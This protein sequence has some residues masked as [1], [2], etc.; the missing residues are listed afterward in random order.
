[1]KFIPALI[2]LLAWHPLQA[3]LHPTDL[4]GNWRTLSIRVALNGE[5][6]WTLEASESDFPETLGI[7]ANYGEYR[8]DS[9]YTETY[10]AAKDSVMASSE[11]RWWVAQDSFYQQTS[12][13]KVFSYAVELK[14]DTATFR[15]WL[16]WDG[17]GQADD[18]YEGQ[19]LR[20]T[21]AMQTYYMV[22]LYRGEQAGDYSLEELEEIQQGHMANI[23][24][25]AKA[26]KLLLAGPFLDDGEL[27]GIFILKVAS[28]EEA[29]AFTQSD[30]AV[31]AGRLRMEVKP[32]YGPAALEAVLEP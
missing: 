9:S 22:L 25:L 13:G 14:G 8:M 20:F 2:V 23:Q 32:W 17:D 11:G 24:R 19:A 21:R 5:P 7:F 15:G 4:A 30:P 27:R 16:D 10:L 1:M 28:M 18:R 31:Q 6:S 26:G 3:Q 29:E 12:E